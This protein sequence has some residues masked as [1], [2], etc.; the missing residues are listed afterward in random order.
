MSTEQQTASASSKA[1]KTGIVHELRAEVGEP[2]VRRIVPALVVCG[3]IFAVIGA[4]LIALFGGGYS[5][6]ALVASPSVTAQ[7]ETLN[8]TSDPSEVA[9]T[10]LV[11]AGIAAPVMSE[12]VSQKLGISNLRRSRCRSSRAMTI[13]QFQ[14]KGFIGAASCG[15][16]EYVGE[17]V[18]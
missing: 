8:P 11:Y 18:R 3:F 17:C 6:S 14:A 1:A 10:E 4:I 16:R 12:A 7:F 13:L 5:A 15:Y 9:Q 2:T